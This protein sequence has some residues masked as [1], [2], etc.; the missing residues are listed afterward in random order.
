MSAG[1][2]SPKLPLWAAFSCLTK[3]FRPQKFVFNGLRGG[4]KPRKHPYLTILVV[5]GAQTVKCKLWTERLAEKGLSR[6]V[7]RGGLKKAHKP[8]ELEANK[9][10]KPWIREGRLP[11]SA[12][13]ELGTFS[14]E[15]SS[16]SVH[17][18]HFMVCA[19]L[20]LLIIKGAW[21]H[22]KRH[23]TSSPKLSQGWLHVTLRKSRLLIPK[24]PNHKTTSLR[25]VCSETPRCP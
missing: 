1:P 18:L 17:S 14:L 22:N 20:N 7:S 25:P 16:V 23:L 2:P 5:E 9:A 19:F 21:R 4:S 15:N 13:H 6:G 3:R 12:N 11:W 24:A 8:Y 10:H